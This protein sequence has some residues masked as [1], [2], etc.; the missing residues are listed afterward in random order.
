LYI[1]EELILPAEKTN[2]NPKTLIV[3]EIAPP[4]HSFS[5][6]QVA[7]A[8]TNLLKITKSV[9]QKFKPVIKAI[10]YNSDDKKEYETKICL[11]PDIKNK[12]YPT[13]NAA[14]EEGKDYMSKSEIYYTEKFE[15]KY[16][17]IQGLLL[18]ILDK[19]IW[20][21]VPAKRISIDKVTVYKSKDCIIELIGTSISCYIMVAKFYY[22]YE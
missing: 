20:Q 9:V 7:T 14:I 17:E 1:Y 10:T 21:Q 2:T 3:K 12:V 5:K 22:Y 4:T 8:K 16:E 18:E 13:I 19:N 11:F 15:Y 6:L